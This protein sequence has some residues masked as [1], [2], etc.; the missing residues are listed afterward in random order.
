MERVWEPGQPQP[1]S[2]VFNTDPGKPFHAKFAE[3]ALLS[4]PAMICTL[5]LFFQ[6]LVNLYFVA[7]LKE[8]E[9]LVAIGLANLI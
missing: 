9:L 2:L 4:F 5:I 6:E 1:G 8:T 7:Q 3:F